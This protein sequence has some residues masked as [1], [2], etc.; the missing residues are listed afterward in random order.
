MP[1]SASGSQP[2]SSTTASRE[3]L[4]A[5]FD[6]RGID[7]IFDW[8][9]NRAAS[10]PFCY[11]VTPNV[12]HMVKLNSTHPFVNFFSAAYDGAALRVCDSRVLSLLARFRGVRLPIVP[13]SD[14]TAMLV[15]HAVQ[16]GDVVSIIG[17]DEA[18]L[19]RLR[20][21]KPHVHFV[22]HVPPMGLARNA[23][24]MLAAARFIAD[25]PARFCFLAVGA[26]QQEIL[27][28]LV[29]QEGRSTGLGLCIGASLDFLTGRQRRA[30]LWLQRARLE[31]L[32]RLLS[33][34]RRF[35]RRYLVDG[36][37]VFHLALRWKRALR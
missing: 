36:P 32:Y 3:F 23:P 29:A 35:W 30:P 20:N 37:R 21:R 7:E 1:I 25:N 16:S 33:N 2:S 31:W 24:A 12:D 27:A 14:L 28:H 6:G 8:V 17:G 26:P 13:G 5:Q 34:P 9:M 15:K 11:V 18:V 19:E 10:A 4:G 22:Q